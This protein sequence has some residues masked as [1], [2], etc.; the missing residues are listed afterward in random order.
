MRRMAQED[1]RAL[2]PLIWEHVNS[3]GTF[4]LDMN[5]RLNL[6]AA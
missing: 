3:Y 1:L 2:T 5:Q 4:E 6:D